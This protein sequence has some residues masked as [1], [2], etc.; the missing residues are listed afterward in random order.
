MAFR[1]RVAHPNRG[2]ILYQKCQA[3]SREQ[4]Y[5]FSSPDSCPEDRNSNPGLLPVMEKTLESASFVID[6][7]SDSI[8]SV[9]LRV[10]RPPQYVAVSRASVHIE[11]FSGSFCL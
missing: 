9:V 11:R 7:T 3:L 2:S 8:S 5:T 10:S 4:T 6:S 1:E